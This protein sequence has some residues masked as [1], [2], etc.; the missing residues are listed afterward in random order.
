MGQRR[1]PSFIIPL[2]RQRLYGTAFVQGNS[3]LPHR[4]P[5]TGTW[6]AN[7]RPPPLRICSTTGRGGITP[8]KSQAWG[9]LAR[10][11]PRR[12]PNSTATTTHPQTAQRPTTRALQACSRKAS[13]TPAAP[14]LQAN[15]N[16]KRGSGAMT[17]HP[18]RVALCQTNNKIIP[19]SRRRRRA[20]AQPPTPSAKGSKNKVR[21]ES[22]P[23]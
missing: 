21:K 23:Q 7:G 1:K 17:N 13:A 10:S 9:A 3:A 6:T 19:V 14:K 4:S 20:H 11:L 12:T 15:P 8:G 16:P 2:R 5:S 18:A 22:L